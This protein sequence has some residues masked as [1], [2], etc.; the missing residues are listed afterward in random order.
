MVNKI[1][2]HLRTNLVAYLALFIALGGS[3]AFAA[4]QLKKNSVKSKQIKDGG[5]KTQDLA[6]GA[7]SAEKVGG[8]AVRPVVIDDGAITAAKLADGSIGSP[9]VA[10]DSLSGADVDESTLSGVDAETVGGLRVKKINYQV[11][12]GPS[13]QAVLE[14]PGVFRIDASCQAAGDVLDISAASGVNGAVVSVESF[15]HTFANDTDNQRD[16]A[17]RSDPQFNAGET[18]EVDS[19]TEGLADS[20]ITVHF[21]TPSGFVSTTYLWPA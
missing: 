16:I 20:D 10:D 12:F 14:Y 3:G 8:G 21:A 9:K 1:R 19:T 2:R 18:I 11:P 15:D 17:S 6:D 13:T 5:I 4:Q 7:V